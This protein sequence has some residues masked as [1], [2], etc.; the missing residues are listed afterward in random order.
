MIAPDMTSMTAARDLKALPKAELH[1]HMA[2]AGP[3][4]EQDIV[5]FVESRAASFTRAWA[6]STGRRSNP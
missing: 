3:A 2:G 1:L 5:S 4:L 6:G